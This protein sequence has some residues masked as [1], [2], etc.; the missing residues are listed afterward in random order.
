MEIANC[1][2]CGNPPIEVDIDLWRCESCAAYGRDALNY[3]LPGWNSLNT[4][5]HGQQLQMQTIQWTEWDGD[6]EH[7]PADGTRIFHSAP[8]ELSKKTS[9]LIGELKSSGA[10]PYVC[11]QWLLDNGP[12]V[13][14]LKICVI[15]GD[16]FAVVGE[17]SHA[18]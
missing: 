9:G 14:E 17:D 6:V 1:K 12:E 4:D 7:L 18:S 16:L 5:Q 2:Y 3:F 13:Y 8:G 15:K 10:E 11:F